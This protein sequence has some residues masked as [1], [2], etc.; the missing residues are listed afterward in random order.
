M[1][2]SFFPMRYPIYDDDLLTYPK[3]CSLAG[4]HAVRKQKIPCQLGSFLQSDR[5]EYS[6]SKR[7]VKALKKGRRK[8]GLWLAFD[9]LKV[10]NIYE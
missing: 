1:V 3:I 8:S 5:W 6:T 10:Y 7:R 4:A 9:V 2:Q